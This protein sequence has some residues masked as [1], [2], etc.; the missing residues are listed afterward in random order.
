MFTINKNEFLIPLYGMTIRDFLEKSIG[1]TPKN[2]IKDGLP[3]Y[4]AK[5]DDK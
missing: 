1:H 3:H 4:G 2:L 5:R